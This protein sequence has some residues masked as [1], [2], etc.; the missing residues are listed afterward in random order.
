[1]AA[2]TTRNRLRTKTP[3]QGHRFTPADSRMIEE[4]MKGL[5]P[6]ARDAYL[7]AYA[8]EALRVTQQRVETDVPHG[9]LELIEKAGLEP[10]QAQALLLLIQGLT[11]QEVG[12]RMRASKQTTHARAKAAI[13]RIKALDPTAEGGARTPLEILDAMRAMQAQFRQEH[14]P[15]SELGYLSPDQREEVRRAST[16]DDRAIVEAI[17][18]AREDY[19][20][21]NREH[22]RQ[23]DDSPAPVRGAGQR[24]VQGRTQAGPTA[25]AASRAGRKAAHARKRG[26]PGLRR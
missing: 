12:D 17:K 22:A 9:L 7:D 6:A 16:F 24:R 1:M 4:R 3:E 23:A 19:A 15:V 25:A 8:T 13:L 2:A 26:C 10:N 21:V 5:S 18:Q 20:D 14:K 11:T